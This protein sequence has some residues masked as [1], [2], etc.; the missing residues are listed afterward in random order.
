VMYKVSV[1]MIEIYN[2][3]I[4]DL[5]GNSGSEKKLGILNASQPNGLAVPDATMHPVNSSSDVIELM[6]TGL[7]NRSVG[8][9]ALN[10]RSSRSHR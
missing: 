3:Q 10:E 9:T 4:H 5:L 8:A 2:E 7:E 1:Q 6:R